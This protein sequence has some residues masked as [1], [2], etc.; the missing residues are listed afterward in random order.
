[1]RRKVYAAPAEFAELSPWLPSRPVAAL[2]SN[3][4]PTATV[5]PD[6]ATT[7][8]NKSMVPGFDALRYA[9]CVQVAPER[10][11]TYAAPAP[12]RVLSF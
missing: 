11:K 8:P 1:M 9:C 2:S 3:S 4:A 6:T 5:S 7:L 12:E 10:V